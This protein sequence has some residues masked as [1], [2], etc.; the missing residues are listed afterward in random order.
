MYYSY[1]E[2]FNSNNNLSV[3]VSIYLIKSPTEKYLLTKISMS[4][5]NMKIN[6]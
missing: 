2:F 6:N 4:I 5:P 1:K 3:T